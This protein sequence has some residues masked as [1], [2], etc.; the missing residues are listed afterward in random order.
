M[1][2]NY[3]LFYPLIET[4]FPLQLYTENIREMHLIVVYYNNMSPER[5][6]SKR[7]SVRNVER[8]LYVNMIAAENLN[9]IVANK[10]L[11]LLLNFL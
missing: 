4:Y 10:L 8:F 5:V 7:E 6:K 9:K 3:E 2:L 1:F 11:V